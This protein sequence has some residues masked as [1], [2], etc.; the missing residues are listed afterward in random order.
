MVD[1]MKEAEGGCGD[2]VMAAL[3]LGMIV[4][5]LISLGRRMTR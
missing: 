4:L 2:V 5:A 3:V 1:A